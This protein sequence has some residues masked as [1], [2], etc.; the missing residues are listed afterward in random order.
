VIVEGSLLQILIEV[1]FIQV[2]ILGADEE[3]G[4]WATYT[5]PELVEPNSNNGR[6]GT[7]LTFRDWTWIAV[8]LA[9]FIR[10][11]YTD[12]QGFLS[13]MTRFASWETG[14]LGNS[15][16]ASAKCGFGHISGCCVGP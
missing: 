16:E 11:H 4:F 8:T 10:R 12:W 14:Q 5:V 1:A 13:C 7:R 9:S 3:K 15:D 2:Y 6:K